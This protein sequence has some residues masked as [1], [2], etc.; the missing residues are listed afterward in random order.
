M[1]ARAHKAAPRCSPDRRP[2]RRWS[3]LAKARRHGAARRATIRAE[4]RSGRRPAQPE[5]AGLQGRRDPCGRHRRGTL[6]VKLTS[7][8]ATI[9]LG[10]GAVVAYDWFTTERDAGVAEATVPAPR[11]T[12]TAADFERPWGQQSTPP[13]GVEAAPLR[14]PR[15]TSSAPTTAPYRC[16]GR[17]HCSQMRSCAEAKYFLRHCPG[18]SMDGDGDGIPCERQ[19]CT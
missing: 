6:V 16:D 2:A 15:A 14:T 8:L 7:L 19:W 4:V 3:P 5:A 18:T 13:G 1:A 12:P 10:I 17:T 11:G 9:A